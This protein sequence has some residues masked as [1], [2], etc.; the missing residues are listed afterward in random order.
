MD[1]CTS[2]WPSPAVHHGVI[3]AYAFTINT[4]FLWAV[5]VAA[6]AF[7]LTWLLPDSR[8]GANQRFIPT[9][10]QVR[11]ISKLPPQ[12]FSFVARNASISRS[13]PSSVT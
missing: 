11:A 9:T 6:L 2:T 8:S 13:A 10:R 1:S 3:E 5:P 7:L 12:M 4:V